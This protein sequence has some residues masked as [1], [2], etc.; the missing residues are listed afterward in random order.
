MMKNLKILALSGVLASSLFALQEQNLDYISMSMGDAGVATSYGSMSAYLNPALV[1]NKDNKR[2]EIGISAG[3]GIQEH[4]LGDPLYK[5]DEAEVGDTLDKIANGEGDN[6]DTKDK[7]NQITAALKE[8]ANKDNYLMLSPTFG[9]SFKIGRH[10]SLGAYSMVNA[11]I[12]A[13]IDNTRLKYISHVQEDFEYNGETYETDDYVKYDPNSEGNAYSES[14]EDEYKA[15]SIEYAMEEEGSTY[16]EVK[17]ISIIE[18]PLT[19]ANNFEA[20]GS[21]INWGISAKYMAGSTTSTKIK[22][23]EDDYDPVDELDKNTKDTSTFGVDAGII[24][25]PKDSGFK[26][27]IAGK[28]LNTPEF[29]VVDGS[30]YELEPKITAG[31][32]YSATDMIDLTIDYDFTELTDELTNQKYQYVGGGI[33]FHPLTWFSLR[34][35]AKKNLSDDYNG[36][37]YTTGVSFGLKWL[38]LDA[39]VQ[40]SENSG[41][42]DGNEIPRYVK[43]NIALVSKWGDN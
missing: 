30:T 42:Y 31:V 8:L 15:K 11:K 13:I 14:N 4:E 33:N 2:T 16:L 36:M 27:A 38:Q 32:A 25:Q 26:L 29:D 21:V 34:A 39:A 40:V 3:I 7:A 9:L 6:P 35:G 10:W 23:T 18:I 22:F 20:L 17:G 41:D 37:I 43:A 19:Y 28:N 5:L 24:I 12:K 1:N